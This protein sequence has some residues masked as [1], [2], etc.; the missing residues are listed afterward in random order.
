MLT[1]DAFYTAAYVLHKGLD[2]DNLAIQFARESLLLSAEGLTPQT[3]IADEDTL[4]SRETE[5]AERILEESGE[6]VQ[7]PFPQKLV[8]EM[9]EGLGWVYVSDEDLESVDASDVES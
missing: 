8:E 7:S 2:S 6:P 4:H 1:S 3:G 9:Y 5:L